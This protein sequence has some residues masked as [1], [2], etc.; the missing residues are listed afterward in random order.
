MSTHRLLL[1]RSTAASWVT[2]NPILGEG[3]P[4]YEKDTNRMKIGDGYT[5]WNDLPYFV[6]D[7]DGST[8][9]EHV[10]SPLPHPAYDDGPS[11]SLLYENAK[12]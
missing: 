9:D 3:E 10:N 2:R 12:V 6:T 11:L 8:L 4:G 5:R 1:R 7:A